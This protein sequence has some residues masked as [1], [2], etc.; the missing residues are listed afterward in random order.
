MG[1]INAADGSAVYIRNDIS[2][3]S[4]VVDLEGLKI[5]RAHLNVGGQKIKISTLYRCHHIGKDKF[6]QLINDY[7]NTNQS[8]KNHFIIGGFNIDI[9]TSTKASEELLNNFLEK[10]FSPLF[11]TITR[12]NNNGGSCI[13]NFF[14]KTNI[15][16]TPIV[17]RQP[18]KDHYTILA[19]LHL[20][21]NSNTQKCYTLNY[22]K[23]TNSSNDTNWSEVLTIEEPNEAIEKFLYLIKN[24]VTKATV[25]QKNDNNKNR[26]K[27]RKKWMTLGIYNS[28]LHKELLYNLSRNNKENQTLVM[29]YRKYDKLL[30]KVISTAK[31]LDEIREANN[32]CRTM[33]CIIIKKS[34]TPM[35]RQIFSIIIFLTLVTTLLMLMLT[36]KRNQIYLNLIVTPYT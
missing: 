4:E 12:P 23:L 14:A 34:Q 10:G 20:K 25:L 33:L 11:N 8:L 26:N 16:T 19:C 35:I 22:K 27:F 15:K 36:Y 13:D 24:C 31:R 1:S 2:Y 9:L 6:T 7:V 30:N 17:H 29:E 3:T 18:F 32:K 5:N 21:D 28:I